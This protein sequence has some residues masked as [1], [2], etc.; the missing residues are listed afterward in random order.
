[1]IEEY[2]YEAPE[3]EEEEIEEAEIF[4]SVEEQ[5]EFPGGAP[6]MLEYI[7]KNMQHLVI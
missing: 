4:L 6:K 5:P 2:V 3:I 1:M 7:Q